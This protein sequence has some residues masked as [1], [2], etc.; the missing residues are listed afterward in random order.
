MKRMID[1]LDK[2]Y[3]KICTYAAV[4]IILT[5]IILALLFSSGDLWKTIWNMFTAVLK[6]IILGIVLTFLFL[7]LVKR[8]EKLLG[9][10]GKR[11]TRPAAVVIFYLLAAALLGTVIVLAVFAVKGG[12]ERVSIDEI[13]AYLDMLYNQYHSL[14]DGLEG[15]IADSK[16][17]VKGLG[18]VVAALAN[19]VAG[20][21]SSL[22]FGVIFSIYFMI[23]QD[24][25]RG[26]WGRV[27]K[28]VYGEK[29][30]AKMCELT[31]E[32]NTVFTGYIRGQ[33]IDAAIVGLLT[34][35]LL[36]LAGV[37][38]ATVIGIMTGVG[39]LIP[40]V[41]PVVGFGSIIISCLIAGE[42]DKMIIGGLLLIVIMFVDSNVIN[43][44]LL[45]S[46]IEVHPLLVVASLLAGGAIGGLVG[47]II[48]VPT[49]AFIKL[50][51]DKY[52]DSKEKERIATG[53][54]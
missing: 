40:Y 35:I 11:W 47:M 1:R 37:P 34:I 44:K 31:G 38:N 33:S 32:L 3:S 2:K 45:S 43:P 25:I 20:F 36:S 17:P 50:Q 39:N 24:G 30:F 13:K 5:V 10:P 9:N 29:A 7:P 19:G 52:L 8:I 42:F 6:P 4:T 41:G 15:Y 14:I 21:F 28:V 46:N 54:M 26:Y 48:A 18:K 49:A 53:D 12:I 23:D 51:F 27:V 16:F 22:L